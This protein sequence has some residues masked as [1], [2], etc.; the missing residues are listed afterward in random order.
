MQAATDVC[1]DKNL[2]SQLSVEESVEDQACRQAGTRWGLGSS[3]EKLYQ[4]I[5]HLIIEPAFVAESQEIL[6]EQ[7]E[8]HTHMCCYEESEAWL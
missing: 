1:Q 6:D 2:L 5:Q 7:G 3:I 4:G 8:L